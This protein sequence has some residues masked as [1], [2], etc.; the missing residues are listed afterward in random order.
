[1]DTN[2]VKDMQSTSRMES[3]RA[4]G[5]KYWKKGLAGIAVVAVL[6]GVGFAWNVHR[7]MEQFAARD[8][9]RSQLVASEAAKQGITL[10]SADE[11]QA[12][13]AEAIGA[14]ESA[15]TYRRISLTNL[16]QGPRDKEKK[17]QPRDMGRAPLRPD[18][19][20]EPR[21]AGYGDDDHERGRHHRE[22]RHGDDWC[23]GGGPENCPAYRGQADDQA[24]PMT[25][26]A[27][28][29]DAGRVQPGQQ[30]LAADG[31]QP[32]PMR[33]F[34]PAYQIDCAQGNVK[35]R[36]MVDAVTG[37]TMMCDLL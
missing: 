33:H 14:D 24:V 23:P 13:A 28:Q 16:S 22:G 37:D 5:R 1:M 6:G 25:P 19:E 30:N 31:R 8:A 12:V 9:A 32:R 35:Y 3:A 4:F 21:H 11:A 36:V 34:H 7:H 18:G 2:T 17:G 26:E 20:M 27:G 29:R 15:L 10:I